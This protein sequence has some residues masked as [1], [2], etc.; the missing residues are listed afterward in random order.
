[1]GMLASDEFSTLGFDLKVEKHFAPVPAK[2]LLQ[3]T[4]V[5]CF[6]RLKDDLLLAISGRRSDRIVWLRELKRR[7]G[8]Y[9]LIVDEFSHTPVSML[10]TILSKRSRWEVSGRLDV[11]IKVKHTAQGIPLDSSSAH[12][13][14][15]HKSW[16]Y[17]RFHHF[18]EVSSSRGFFRRAMRQFYMQLYTHFPHHVGFEALHRFLMQTTRISI[19]AEVESWLVLLFH[20]SFEAGRVAEIKK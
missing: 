11:G 20:P 12:S 7:A 10:D 3:G 13:M 2:S 4:E 8:D 16:T 17:G 1:M 9:R 19:K 14:H 18:R 15:V 6:L 5:H